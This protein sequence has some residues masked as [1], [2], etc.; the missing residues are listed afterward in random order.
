MLRVVQ[1][2]GR[3]TPPYREMQIQFLARS[4]L[5]KKEMLMGRYKVGSQTYQWAVL[6][7][8]HALE[9][10]SHQ[11]VPARIENAGAACSYTGRGLSV[12]YADPKTSKTDEYHHLDVRA[13]G[14]KVLSVVWLEDE[15]P[16]IV[17]FKRGDW[18]ENL[19][20]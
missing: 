9:L 13:G 7:K 11:G 15:P 14:L 3:P 18:E 5:T 12:F 16:E 2:P 8:E 17:T 6:L 19:L 1:K 4:I 20:F 10:C